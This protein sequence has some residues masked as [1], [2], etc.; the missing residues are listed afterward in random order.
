MSGCLVDRIASKIIVNFKCQLSW[1]RR[2]IGG[3]ARRRSVEG[4]GLE[5]FFISCLVQ[6]LKEL[7][8]IEVIDLQFII[9][10]EEDNWMRSEEEEEVVAATTTPAGWSRS[11]KGIVIEFAKVVLRSIQKNKLRR[12]QSKWLWMRKEKIKKTKQFQL[13][14]QFE[15]LFCYR[16]WSFAAYPLSPGGFLDL[17]DP[18][19]LWGNSPFWTECWICNWFLYK[20]YKT[21]PK[22]IDLQVEP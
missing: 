13:L 1:S 20:Q 21:K 19:L 11:R 8:I 16:I 3:W 22:R 2:G 18:Q 10:N 6:R 4:K 9:V 12:D 14:F 7:Y 5:F 17:G 15:K